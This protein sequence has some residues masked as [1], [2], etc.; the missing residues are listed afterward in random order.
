MIRDLNL[1]SEHGILPGQLELPATP[2][3]LILVARAQ[4][5][6]ADDF[7][8]STLAEQ[9][10]AVLTM[11]LLSSRELQFADAIHNIPRLTQ[12]LL[13]TLTLIQQDGDTAELPLML[14]TSGDLTPAALRAAAQ[15]DTQVRALACHGGLIDQAG[16]Q[17]LQLLAA[18]LLMLFDSD[19]DSGPIA[20]QRARR[21]LASPAEMRALAPGEDQLPILADWFSRHLA[22]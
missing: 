9:R 5:A 2:R 3:G 14:L 16:L 1:H 17:Y 12:R 18:P 8:R 15:R 11:A 22:G 20:W 10:F 7:L 13:D 4:H 19:D 6:P 21:H